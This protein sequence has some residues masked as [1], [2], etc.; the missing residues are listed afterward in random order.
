MKTLAA[1]L[2]VCAAFGLT[3]AQ[4]DDATDK[5]R[6]RLPSPLEGIA[7][8]LGV[9]EKHF[10]VVESKLYGPDEFTAGNRLVA[11]ETIVFTLEAKAPL[12]AEEVYDLLRP[13]PPPSPF[14]KARFFKT[15]DGKEVA[16]DG[17]EKGYSLI[18]DLRWLGPKT[19]PDLAK[20]DKLQI[21]LHLGKEGS[22]GLIEQRATRLLVSVK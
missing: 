11:E 13:N 2:T 22:A 5:A 10:Q 21:W 3:P 4:A 17:R 7:C 16:A 12:P 18:G 1:A 9:L 20:G 19:G 14:Y 8:D 6:Q 15:I